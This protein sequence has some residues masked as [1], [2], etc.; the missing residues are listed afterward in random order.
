MELET[1]I[2]ERSAKA[3]AVP[4]IPAPPPPSSTFA[5]L[6][7]ILHHASV[8]SIAH[9]VLVRAAGGFVKGAW[10]TGAE[11]LVSDGLVS[12]ALHVLVS[13]MREDSIR[14]SPTVPLAQLAI[15]EYTSQGVSLLQVL[16]K[17][18]SSLTAPTQKFSVL[19]IQWIFNTLSLSGQPVIIEALKHA[20][21][22]VTVDTSAADAQLSEKDR[23]KAAAKAKQE[24]L[25]AKF[26]NMTEAFVEENKEAVKALESQESSQSRQDDDAHNK[27]FCMLCQEQT[28]ITLASSKPMVLLAMAQRSSMLRARS[29][30]PMETFGTC[31]TV[32]E[33]AAPSVSA[34][35]SGLDVTVEDVARDYRVVNATDDFAD[36]DEVDVEAEFDDGD[37]EDDDEVSMAHIEPGPADPLDLLSSEVGVFTR[38]CGHV[39][40]I[41][42]YAI[43]QQGSARSSL[44][45]PLCSA[46]FNTTIPVVVPQPIQIPTAT[47]P[48]FG[49]N[50]LAA[51][52]QSLLSGG[53]RGSFESSV[54]PVSVNAPAPA[55][56]IPNTP[57]DGA[58]LNL[59]RRV[60]GEQFA[61]RIAGQFG[62]PRPA[63]HP[64]PS[65]VSQQ[66]AIVSYIG[67]IGKL[68]RYEN[69]AHL[70]VWSM[71]AYTIR[72]FEISNRPALTHAPL[73]CLSA[74]QVQ[75]LS[76]LVAS[77]R[78]FNRDII[79]P[80]ATSAIVDA[81]EKGRNLLK[82]C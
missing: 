13:A 46:A 9:T 62:Q 39:M 11:K 56:G 53:F 80:A 51:G 47:E 81:L 18:A 24:Q 64:A 35:P 6:P 37:W 50:Q 10:T 54:L 29:D 17:L 34:A 57:D 5:A 12:I 45:C 58:M 27:L 28:D 67:S 30:Q 73:A 60:L 23:R 70:S 72:C 55:Q 69:D 48:K 14:S 52:F 22:A 4:V 43:F 44:A 74:R 2:Q 63:A 77:G 8:L 71:I 79:S 32:S 15:C 59:F 38:S 16:A 33:P 66:G 49:L 65:N 36:E 41:D 1:A 19:T 31:R 42:C 26:A 3:G 68:A 40:H 61:D 82:F 25:K 7:G 75:Y 21:V 76:H 20:G 78:T